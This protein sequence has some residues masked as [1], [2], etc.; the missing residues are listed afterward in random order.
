MKATETGR[1]RQGCIG[2][3]AAFSM[4]FVQ[5]RTLAGGVPINGTGGQSLCPR[6]AKERHVQNNYTL[7]RPRG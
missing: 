6:Q 7:K 5:A 4:S 1:D 2:N 3:D